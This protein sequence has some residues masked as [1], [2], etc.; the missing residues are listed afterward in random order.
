MISIFWNIKIIAENM[1]FVEI[2]QI[3]LGAVFYLV[4]VALI[5]RY[6]QQSVP[7]LIS[8]ILSLPP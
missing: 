7:S 8:I 4:S 2:C 6:V 3:L 1:K 5:T